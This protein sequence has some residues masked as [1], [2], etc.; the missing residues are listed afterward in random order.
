MNSNKT[1]QM[2]VDA[3]NISACLLAPI[4]VMACALLAL[5][6]ELRLAVPLLVGVTAAMTMVLACAL[7]IGVR[8]LV[9][10]SPLVILA[11]ALQL[12][13]QC[14]HGHR[15]FGRH[16]TLFAVDKAPSGQLSAVA[17]IQILGY[18]V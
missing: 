5:E 14:S 2:Q 3:R 11:V 7:Y 15:Q 9:S 1:L 13:P 12:A 4:I 18:R 17:Q 16:L 8:G 10:W 6:A